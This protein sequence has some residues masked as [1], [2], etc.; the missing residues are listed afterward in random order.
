MHINQSQIYYLYCFF[1]ILLHI[2]LQSRVYKTNTDWDSS[3]HLYFAFLKNKGIRIR[4]SYSLGIKWILPRIYQFLYKFLIN[5]PFDHRIVNTIFGIS[6]ILQ[7]CF[8]GKIN[9]GISTYFW[10][11]FLI[12]IVNS[13]YINYQTSASEF[14]DTPLILLILTSIPIYT[15]YLILIP[16]ILIIFISFTTKFINFLYIFPIIFFNYQS[17]LDLPPLLILTATI[18][19]LSL[20]FLYKLCIKNIKTYQNSR[21]FFIHPKGIRYILTNPLWI[22]FNSLL[23]IQILNQNNI[24]SSSIIITAWICL[25]SQKSLVGYYWYPI[26][27]FNLYYWYSLGINSS[28]ILEI[29]SIIVFLW[30]IVC[31]TICCI[32]PKYVQPLFQL[33]VL[34]NI[35]FNNFNSTFK[36]IQAINWI[37]ENLDDKSKIYLWG[38]KTLIPLACKLEHVKDTFYTHNHLMFWSKNIDKLSYAK[39][40]INENKP[41]YIIEAGVINKFFFP[42]YDFKTIYIKIFDFND[43]KIFKRE[44]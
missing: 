1:C 42:E 40:V 6:L 12:L 28:N 17:L 35:S 39:K 37:K 29:L 4:A 30:M 10:L 36:D 26:A 44:I 25:I 16:L 3:S 14:L 34:G 38:S 5:K 22:I 9:I 8:L 43:I 11:G 2:F 19:I 18:I 27:I 32:Y 31:S 7:F 15:D 23:S 41:N 21:G 33:L 24:L 20:F 13:L